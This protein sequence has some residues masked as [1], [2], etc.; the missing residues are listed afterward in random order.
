[1]FLN[2]LFQFFLHRYLDFSY[3]NKKTGGREGEEEPSFKL[4]VKIKR[5]KRA[6]NASRSFKNRKYSF[7]SARVPVLLFPQ[8]AFTAWCLVKHREKFTFY[9]YELY[10]RTRLHGLQL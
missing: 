1:V 4:R 3:S 5:N 2:I 7:P 6:H 8:Y 9:L 10:Y